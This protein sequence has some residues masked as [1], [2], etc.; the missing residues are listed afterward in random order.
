[1]GNCCQK[2]KR[3]ILLGLEFAGKTSILVKLYYNKPAII[4]PTMGFNNETISYKKLKIH[5]FDIGGRKRV[6]ILYRHYY[7]GVRL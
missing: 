4:L 6:E 7:P 5:M 1:M 2:K 3:V